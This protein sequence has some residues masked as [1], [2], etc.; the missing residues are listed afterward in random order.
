M[1]T[2]PR[3]TRTLSI[4]SPSAR[5]RL[6]MT[7]PN[8]SG[9]AAISRRPLAMPS[10]RFSSSFNRSSKAADRPALRPASTSISFLNRMSALLSTRA[11]AISSSARFRLSAEADASARLAALACTQAWTSSSR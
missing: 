3:G 9:K 10:T 8:G 5:E 6:S 7:F 2:T 4:L 11:S 1:A